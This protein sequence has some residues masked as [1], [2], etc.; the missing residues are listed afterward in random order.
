MATSFPSMDG[1]IGKG[2]AAQEDWHFDHDLES[3]LSEDDV[4]LR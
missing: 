2:K 3:L 4:V 1:Q